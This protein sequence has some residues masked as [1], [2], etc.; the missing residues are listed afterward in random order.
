MEAIFLETL[1]NY[2]FLKTLSQLFLDV[3]IVS[4]GCVLGIMFKLLFIEMNK[5]EVKEQQFE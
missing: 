3:S 5:L 2:M 1:E 4:I